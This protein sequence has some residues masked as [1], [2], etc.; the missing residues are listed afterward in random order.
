M[1][2]L[3]SKRMLLSLAT[4]VLTVLILLAS[5]LLSGSSYGTN[6]ALPPAADLAS[7]SAL[8]PIDAHV[9]LYKDDPAFARLMDRLKLHVLDICVIDD[10]DPDYSGLEPQRS[11]V[12]KVRE[13]TGGR[14]AF[15][16]TFSPYDFEK[17]GSASV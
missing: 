16:T 7:F 13:R 1:R 12:L 6:P 17:P 2:S 4:T 15:C 10:R 14:A 5:V 9:H 8:A 11:E 3:T